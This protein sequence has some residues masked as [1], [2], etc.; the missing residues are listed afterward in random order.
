M[1]EL[2]PPKL[3]LLVKKPVVQKIGKKYSVLKL[4]C[5]LAMSN[6][7]RGKHGGVDVHWPLPSRLRRFYGNTS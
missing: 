6:T 1:G 3:L 5:P 2:E 4:S 7:G